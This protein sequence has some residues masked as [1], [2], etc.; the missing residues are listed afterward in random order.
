MFEDGQKFLACLVDEDN[1]EE[2]EL[3]TIPSP[4]AINFVRT[5]F[6]GALLCADAVLKLYQPFR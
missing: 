1:L 5:H 2:L 4:I 3:G 6:P